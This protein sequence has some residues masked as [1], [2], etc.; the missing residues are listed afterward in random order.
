MKYKSAFYKQVDNGNIAHLY[1]HIIAN[2]ITSKLLSNHLY[3]SF[4]YQLDANHYDGVIRLALNY[5]DK[6]VI[7]IAK[8]ILNSFKYTKK[9]ISNNIAQIS[10]ELKKSLTI[11]E[12]LVSDELIKL[13]I[14]PWLDYKSMSF[15]KYP[16]DSARSFKTK[17]IST[18][19][20]IKDD[21]TT[22]QLVYE[23]NDCPE[24]LRPLSIYVLESV[25]LTVIDQIY[26]SYPD[27]YDDGDEWAMH[28]PLIGYLTNI[29]FA[30]VS[31][32]T[33]KQFSDIQHTVVHELSDPS[34]AKRIAKF[35]SESHAS[36]DPHF[37]EADM[38]DR[39]GHFFG[40]KEFSNQSNTENVIKILKAIEFMVDKS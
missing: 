16:S 24:F 37:S 5:N 28:Q 25:G 34:V 32:Y 18:D 4:D 6:R 30:K 3:R 9:D 13:H 40:I 7:K 19:K 8:N 33:K 15:T 1:E 12:S 11:D 27:I 23:L 10:I 38:Y 39:T 14:Q 21:I 36:L 2:A 26:H 29:L 31:H 17:S 22:Y 35:A 20:S